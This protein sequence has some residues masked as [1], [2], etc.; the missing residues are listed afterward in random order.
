MSKKKV[1][2]TNLVSGLRLAE[3]ITNS[4]GITVIPFGVRLTP[5]FI[6]RLAKWGIDSVD[7]IVSETTVTESSVT[8]KHGTTTNI[9]INAKTGNSVA[10]QEF[11]RDVTAEVTLRFKNLQD[12]E[13]MMRLRSIALKKLIAD[14]PHCKLNR[15]R[16]GSYSSGGN[17]DQW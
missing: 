2:T 3:K 10:L 4:S 17:E 5:L 1:A 13:L 9:A 12:D 11:A 8:L 15:L 6:N 14:G 16:T 7:V